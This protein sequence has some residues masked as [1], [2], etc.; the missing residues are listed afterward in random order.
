MKEMLGFIGHQP[1]PRKKK[2]RTKKRIPKTEA[3]DTKVPD[4]EVPDTTHDTA[5]LV[6]DL[7]K[8]TTRIRQSLNDLY[9][10]DFGEESDLF[11]LWLEIRPKAK[12]ASADAGY[13]ALA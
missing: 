10:D 3:P 5:E 4:T 9:A 8:K 11:Y 1:K 2:K 7:A 12:V 6:D 13:C